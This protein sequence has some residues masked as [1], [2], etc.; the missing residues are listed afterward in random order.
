MILCFQMSLQDFIT[1]IISEERKEFND[2]DSPSLE[3]GMNVY[4][5]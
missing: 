3:G 2:P 4:L 5:L 1:S